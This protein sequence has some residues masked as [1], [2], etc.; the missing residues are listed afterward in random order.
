MYMFFR[1]P[2]N[3]VEKK[4]KLKAPRV[5]S[6][7][8]RQSLEGDFQEAPLEW[9]VCR[10]KNLLD[11]SRFREGRGGLT[12]SGSREAKPMHG[13]TISGIPAL[14]PS[15]LAEAFEE[16]RVRCPGSAGRWLC[17]RRARVDRRDRGQQCQLRFAQKAECLPPQSSR[18]SAGR[19]A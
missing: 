12:K 2:E 8:T 6:E 9:I 18:R 11:S 7:S 15:A 10:Q 13:M 4:E 17:H 3:R 1:I 19:D 14:G 5:S 16:Y